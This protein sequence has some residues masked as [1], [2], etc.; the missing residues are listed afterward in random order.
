MVETGNG[1]L[2]KQ[3]QVRD[4]LL[5]LLDEMRV[6][7]EEPVYARSHEDPRRCRG[8]GFLEQCDEA[9]VDGDE[10]DD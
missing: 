8:C 5:A 10:D 1:R 9:L 2:R 7:L 6:E 4:E 3:S